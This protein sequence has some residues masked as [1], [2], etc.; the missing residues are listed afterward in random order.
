M[1]DGATAAEGQALREGM[2]VRV[3]PTATGA[4]HQPYVGKTGVLRYLVGNKRDTWRVAF[5]EIIKR[6][7]PVVESFKTV[8]LEVVE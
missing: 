2:S 5:P 8:D 3:K 6:G 4:K 1:S 7:T